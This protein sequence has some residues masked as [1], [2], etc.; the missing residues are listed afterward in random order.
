MRHNSMNKVFD[1][2]IKLINR[3]AAVIHCKSDWLYNAAFTGKRA[4]PAI[5]RDTETTVT[6]FISAPIIETELTSL[7]IF[8]MMRKDQPMQAPV[9]LSADMKSTTTGIFWLWRRLT[10]TE[11]RLYASF[12]LYS[13]ASMVFCSSGVSL[14]MPMLVCPQMVAKITPVQQSVAQGI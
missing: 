12:S 9:F 1:V 7:T 2:K 14:R 4:D 8:E 6:P 3:L 5:Y 11:K 10:I 13:S